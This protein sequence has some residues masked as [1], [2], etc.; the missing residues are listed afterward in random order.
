MFPKSFSLFFS[1]TSHARNST[2]TLGELFYFEAIQ[3]SLNRVV[4]YFLEPEEF[5]AAWED[6]T[7]R[8]GIRDHKWIQ[9]LH[10]D[11]KRWVPAYLKQT[12]AGM[13][14]LH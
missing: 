2:Y 1:V 5:E 9:A 14:L 8:H 3:V 6:M 11:R 13:L 7:Q 4:H 12:L 10:E